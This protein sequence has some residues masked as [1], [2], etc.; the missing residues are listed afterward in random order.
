MKIGFRSEIINISYNIKVRSVL[1]I[2]NYI[3]QFIEE[4]NKN[5]KLRACKT[6]IQKFEE[7]NLEWSHVALL[8]LKCGFSFNKKERMIELMNK[9]INM[10]DSEEVLLRN[11]LSHIELDRRYSACI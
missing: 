10:I 7:L 6:L 2:N 8:I 11:L 1:Y 4:Y 3:I 5:A 9:C